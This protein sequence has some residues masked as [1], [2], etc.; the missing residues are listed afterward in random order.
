MKTHCHTILKPHPKQN[1]LFI[2]LFN[3]NCDGGQMICS[4][5]FSV[6]ITEVFYTIIEGQIIDSAL[7]IFKY[8]PDDYKF[9]LW[10]NAFILYNI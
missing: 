5:K 2:R 4:V 1:W 10:I 3:G 7:Y 6:M 8:G 9:Q